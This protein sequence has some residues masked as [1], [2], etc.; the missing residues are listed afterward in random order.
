ML[1]IFGGIALS[2]AGAFTGD[3]IPTPPPLLRDAFAAPGPHPAAAIAWWSVVKGH[4]FAAFFLL[5][6]LHSLWAGFFGQGKLA[7]DDDQA[8]RLGKALKNLRENWFEIIIGNAIGAWVI[9]VLLAAIPNFS[10]WS[11]LGP[12]ILG[13][14]PPL[15]TLWEGQSDWLNW[16]GQNQQKL[17]FWLIYFAG[18]CDDL[19]LPNLKTWGR[20]SWRRWRRREQRKLAAPALTNT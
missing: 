2:F 12:E 14:L 18:A 8:G 11:I 7:G 6:F 1:W 17:N 5:F 15:P 9:A 16:Y 19:G 20:W 4:A 10:L 13:W 3:M